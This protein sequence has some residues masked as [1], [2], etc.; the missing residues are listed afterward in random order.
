MTSPR[1]AV[2]TISDSV[3]SGDATDRSGPLAVAGLSAAGIEILEQ[4]VVPDDAGEIEAELVRLCDAG[5]DLVVTTGGTGLG[6]R[7]VTPEATSAVLDR[8]APGLAELLR[9]RGLEKT[10]LAALSRGI[11]GLRGSTLI[12]NLPGSAAA[13]EEGLE[14][15]KPVLRH[16]L[17]VSSGDTTHRGASSVVD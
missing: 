9:L 17:A 11:A 10:P 6:P 12:I 1:A 14:A 13:V 4:T 5:A 7:D 15:L 3:A 8:P 16:A 2:I